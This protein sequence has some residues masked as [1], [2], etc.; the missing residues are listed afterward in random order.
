MIAVRDP[1]SGAQ[2][3]EVPELTAPDVAAL[4][5][6]AREAQPAWQALGFDGRGKVLRRMQRWVV[7]NADRIA[8][9]IVGETGKAYEDA[10]LAEVMY[11]AAAFGFWAKRAPR[12]VGDRRVRSTAPAVL[13]KRLLVRYEPLG[14][15]GVIGPWNYPLTNSFGDAIPALA[16]GNAVILKPSEHT[17]MTSLLLAEGLAASGVPDGVFAVATGAGPTAEALVDLVD[18][19]Q[20]TGSTATGRAVA[21]RAAERLIPVSL[22]LGGKDPMIVL[23]DAD[24][25]R[26]ANAAVYYAMQN[27][28]QTC[29][30]VE[31]VYVED[32]VHDEFVRLLAERVASLRQGDPRGGPGTVDVGAMT[33]PAQVDVVAEH[34]RDAVTRGAT[35]VAGG[36]RDGAFFP[37]TVLTDVDHSML[38]MREE[39]FGPTL[40]VMRVRDAEEAIRLANDS[41]YGLAASVFTGDAGSWR[42][43]RTPAARRRGHRQRRA[44][45]LPGA[46]AADGRVEELRAGSAPRRGRHPQVLRRAGDRRVALA[47][48]P[49]HPHA[50]VPPGPHEGAA[51]GAA[52]PLRPRPPLRRVEPPGG[53]STDPWWDG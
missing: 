35:V 19:V 9:T 13:G 30:S 23:A 34:V 6:R 31:R 47:P 44:H 17:P 37:P 5:A 42:G 40:P 25:G 3:A 22:E 41:D 52:S 45:Q 14:V 48:A 24:L 27:A 4:V 36:E 2:I 38:A 26:A 28:G 39:T 29:I 51:R 11:G 20:F 18:M 43:D 21:L 16:A 1:V 12:W 46:R 33:T 32:A 49:R 15:V 10:M 8:R 53:G 7:D 50:P